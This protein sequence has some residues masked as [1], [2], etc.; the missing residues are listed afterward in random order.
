MNV[1]ICTCL[2]G[3]LQGLKDL[4][5]ETDVVQMPTKLECPAGNI[6]LNEISQTGKGKSHRISLRCR[7]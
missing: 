3:S 7:I 6:M 2:K 5:L 1:N 4:W